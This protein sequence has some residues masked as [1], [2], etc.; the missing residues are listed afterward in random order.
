MF[1]G[2]HVPDQLEDRCP[3]EC[4]LIRFSIENQNQDDKKAAKFG[5]RDNYVKHLLTFFVKLTI[6]P[7]QL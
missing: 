4:V 7:K 6:V 5:Y 2:G 3:L 1:A